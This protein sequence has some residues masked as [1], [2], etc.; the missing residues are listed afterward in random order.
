MK[1]RNGIEQSRERRG[2]MISD[3]R[4]Y[5][6]RER[7]EEIGQLAAGMVLDFIVKELAPEFYNQGVEDSYRYLTDRVEDMRSL[8]L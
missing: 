1:Q 2:E 4:S 8:M 6:K 5:F 3:I 7:E